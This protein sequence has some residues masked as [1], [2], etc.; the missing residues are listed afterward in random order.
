MKL[1]VLITSTAELLAAP[2]SD[3]SAI[4]DQFPAK[5]QTTKAPAGAMLDT[6]LHTKL[7]Q[8]RAHRQRLHEVFALLHCGLRPA[9]RVD[10]SIATKPLVR[11]S[12]CA[13]EVATIPKVPLEVVVLQATWLRFSWSSEAL[14]HEIPNETSLHGG[15]LL[16]VED[17]VEQMQGAVAVSHRMAVLAHDDR[18]RLGRRERHASFW[19]GVHGADNVAG[20]V[21]PIA[22]DEG[23][24]TVGLTTL[25]LHEAA[26]VA[27]SEPIAAGLPIR[28]EAGFVAQG[29][30]DDA[31]EVFVPPEHG[32]HAVQV[33]TSPGWVALQI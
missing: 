8:T 11:C 27:R 28:A 3:D 14:V 16:R 9:V 2:E 6:C 31:G 5:H 33:C 19:V 18:S 10:Q 12:G 20:R 23:G 25:E 13:S 21:P 15:V 24:I 17:V 26:R 4:V 22:H 7:T 29:P 1:Q 32:L 30:A